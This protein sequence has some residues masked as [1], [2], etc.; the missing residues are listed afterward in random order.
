MSRAP[1]RFSRSA[2]RS[3]RGSEPT[4]A[5]APRVDNFAALVRAIK[6]I[7][8]Y[9]VLFYAIDLII[10]WNGQ[11]PAGVPSTPNDLNLVQ[12]MMFS[13]LFVVG[14]FVIDFFRARSRQKQAA[15]APAQ[16]IVVQQ[17]VYM[18]PPPGYAYVPYP[19]QPGAPPLQ[20]PQQAPGQPPQGAP[21]YALYP[22]PAAPP[23]PVPPPAPAP[24]PPA[25]APAP[26]P[27]DPRRKP[28]EGQA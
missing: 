7:L 14:F 24:P 16:V 22:A 18:Q 5:P 17:P 26:P 28:P 12:N 6:D 23:P 8:P 13:T 2:N 25:P 3:S 15:R 1:T 20:P 10:W 11:P 9:A 19:A 27:A 21:Y 4:A